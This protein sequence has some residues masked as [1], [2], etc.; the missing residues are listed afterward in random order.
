MGKII[1]RIAV[2][3]LFIVAVP[4]ASITVILIPF[5]AIFSAVYYIATGKCDPDLLM[6]PIDQAS[7][8]LWRMVEKLENK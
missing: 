4:V 5:T 1:K 6:K 8:I 3:L 7:E 2:V